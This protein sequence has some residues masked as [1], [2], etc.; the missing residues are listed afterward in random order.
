MR[1]GLEQHSRREFC[2]EALWK[3]TEDAALVERNKLPAFLLL[4]SSGQSSKAMIVGPVTEHGKSTVL[5][6]R[7]QNARATL[8][9]S[10]LSACAGQWEIDITRQLGGERKQSSHLY[11]ASFGQVALVLTLALRSVLIIESLQSKQH[12][13]RYQRFRN[14]FTARNNIWNPLRMWLI[15][16][17]LGTLCCLKKRNQVLDN[18]CCTSQL[19]SWHHE[20]VLF[21]ITAL[22]T[23]TL[24][25]WLQKINEKLLIEQLYEGSVDCDR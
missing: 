19:Q 24:F 18:G 11:C 15:A 25:T 20:S 22:F 3:R 6:C 9:P 7:Y 21:K 12:H 13:K 4:A 17:L 14:T 16:F 1:K 10:E 23:C 5:T 2:K 8:V